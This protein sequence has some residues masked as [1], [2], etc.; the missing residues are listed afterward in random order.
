MKRLL[1]ILLLSSVFLTC[2]SQYNLEIKT[3]YFDNYIK[4]EKEKSQA[5]KV[6]TVYS[7]SIIFDAVGD[8][9]NDS[10]EKQWGHFCNAAS[11]GIMLT[12]PFI[13]DY[14]KSKWGWYLTSYTSLRIALFDYSYNL[15]RGLPLNYIGGTSTWDKVLGKMNPPDTY[16]GR[17]VFFILGVSIPINKL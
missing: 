15:T 2:F 11:I 4:A 3:D 10:G 13:I 9:L 6:I 12:S 1:I 16:M 5:W 14:E 17:G 8:G 7:S